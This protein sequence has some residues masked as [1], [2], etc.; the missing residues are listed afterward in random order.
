MTGIRVHAPPP[1]SLA[2]YR[3]LQLLAAFPTAGIPVSAVGGS[4]PRTFHPGGDGPAAAAT[5]TS[6]TVDVITAVDASTP[7][8][9]TLCALAA[10]YNLN[11]V[12]QA[13]G[14]WRRGGKEE[15]LLLT[16]LNIGLLRAG[17]PIDGPA[18]RDRVRQRHVLGAPR[19]SSAARDGDGDAAGQLDNDGLGEARVARRGLAALP[20]C[21]GACGGD[22]R[23]AA[24]HP[25]RA[26]RAGAGR[27]RAHC[28][29]PRPRA[30][31]RRLPARG[32]A[33]VAAGIPFRERFP[34]AH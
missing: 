8:R 34:K 16:H 25:Q 15:G 9:L 4:A 22:A 31:R 11:I 12:D 3:A 26:R 32:R 27:R 21:R 14:G 18:H 5:A 6:G 13:R 1:P 30:L 2:A 10:N 29:P 24:R 23:V 7:P 28:R 20:G 33:R 17:G 19:V